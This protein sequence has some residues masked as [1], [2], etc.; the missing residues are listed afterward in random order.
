MGSGA[1]TI[2]LLGNVTGVSWPK[3]FFP[4]LLLGVSGLILSYYL[5]I[6]QGNISAEV[7]WR[8]TVSSGRSLK[9]KYKNKIWHIIIAII[10]LIILTMAFINCE[11]T[12]ASQGI[13]L[14]G[15][16]V[17]ALW[18]F[19]LKQESY[20]K[21]GLKKY[22]EKDLLKAADLAPFFIAIGF[23]SEAFQQSGLEHYLEFMIQGY[24]SGIGIWVICLIPLIMIVLSLVGFHPLI[25]VVLFG[26][27]LMIM[28]LPIPTI[29]IAL[30]LNVGSSI[31]YMMSPF[32][33]I[34]MTIAKFI[35]A[36]AA[37]VGFCWNWLFCIFY[38]VIGVL[39]AYYWGIEFT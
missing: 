16:I 39:M 26:K 31:S 32:A 13:I 12:S 14:S 24:V 33:G 5:E 1:A 28:H 22:W 17:S 36:K 10:L 38:F 21:S 11:I 3:I 6:K 18:M 27:I 20:F 4:S 35:N 23:F 2:F 25:S 9:R 34:I 15:C 37:N 30:C 8:G 7:V 19:L 29:T